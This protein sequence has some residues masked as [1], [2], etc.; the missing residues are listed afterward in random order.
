MKDEWKGFSYLLCVSVICT[1]LQRPGL[2]PYGF[3]RSQLR[4]GEGKERV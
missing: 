3:S 4:S 1:A 2:P